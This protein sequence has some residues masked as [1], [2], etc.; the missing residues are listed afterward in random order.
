MIRMQQMGRLSMQR[1]PD[2]GRAVF[3]LMA[4][5]ESGV[6]PSRDSISLSGQHG[7]LRVRGRTGGAVCGLRGRH[8]SGAHD[9]GRVGR[10][11]VRPRHEWPGQRRLRL[12]VQPTPQGVAG[13]ARI[14]LHGELR[15]QQLA[16][17][18]LDLDMDVRRAACGVRPV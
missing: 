15:C 8:F 17:A 11:A 9:D 7:E 12:G 13:I 14:A 3:I 2:V 1:F 6:S 16:P 18:E 4:A 10:E 5:K